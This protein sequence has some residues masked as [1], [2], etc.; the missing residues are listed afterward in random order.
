M[1]SEMITL[2]KP[3]QSENADWPMLVTL[4]GMVALVR[5]MQLENAD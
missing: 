2:V 5:P 4:E 3:M 1:P